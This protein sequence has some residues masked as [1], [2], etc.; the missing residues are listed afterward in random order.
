MR[1]LWLAV[2]LAG[3]AAGTLHGHGRG[4]IQASAETALATRVHALVD[5]AIAAKQLPGAVVVVGHGDR[6]LVRE[7][8][9]ARATLP[10]REPMTLD[11]IFDS[12]SLTK[13]V[14]TTTSVMQLVEEGRLRLIDPVSPPPPRLRA[15]REARHHH[16]PPAHAHLRPPA[17][18]RP[19]RPLDRRRAR[20]RARDRRGAGGPRRRARDLQ[21]H[22]FLPARADRRARS[23]ASRSIA[24]RGPHLH[25]ARDARHRRS[26]RARRCVPRI[27]PTERCPPNE[28]CVPGAAAS[29][30]PPMLRGVVHDPTARRMGGVAGHAGLFTTAD[31]MAR[32]CRMLLGGRAGRPARSSRRCRSRE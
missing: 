4:L 8:I 7:A 2:A 14:A 13:V 27:A 9:G 21:R 30:A 15:L 24:S 5:D 32:F 12:A 29:P 25:A 11:T 23:A 18:R 6:V 1:A 31:D 17:R 16:P 22:Q 3:A 26:G 10:T 20:A 19:G 28:P